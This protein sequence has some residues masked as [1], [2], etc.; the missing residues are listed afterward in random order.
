[1]KEQTPIEFIAEMIER[2]HLDTAAIVETLED[3]QGSLDL[4]ADWLERIAV[5]LEAQGD[6]AD[7][8]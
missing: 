7:Q 2:Y 4:I 8:S 6:L 3:I 5:A 1:M